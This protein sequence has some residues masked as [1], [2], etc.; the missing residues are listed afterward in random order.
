MLPQREFQVST[1]EIKITK[2]PIMI[3]VFNP[4]K[5]SISSVEFPISRKGSIVYD[6]YLIL[7]F[8]KNNKKFL[9]KKIK[10]YEIGDN[11]EKPFVA[12]LPRN[13]NDNEFKIMIYKLKGLNEVNFYKSI[14]LDDL[15][16]PKNKLFKGYEEAAKET[17]INVNFKNKEQIFKINFRGQYNLEDILN[18]IKFHSQGKIKKLFFISYLVVSLI[19]VFF[20][21][22]LLSFRSLNKLKN[23]NEG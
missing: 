5:R 2:K 12:I 13:I 22:L 10:D 14:F 11:F 3:S 7:D 4:S 16:K 9:S 8:Y 17:W 1:E 23:K 18:A 20:S 6:D 15:N 19:I 21:I